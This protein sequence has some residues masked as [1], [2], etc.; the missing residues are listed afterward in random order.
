MANPSKVFIASCNPHFS[1]TV[2]TSLSGRNHTF[3]FLLVG[4]FLHQF[5]LYLLYL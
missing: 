5:H 1:F 3:L 2:R 4:N